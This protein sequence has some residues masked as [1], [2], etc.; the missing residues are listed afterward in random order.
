MVDALCC[1]LGK[2]SY[3]YDHKDIQL[4]LN[5]FTVILLAQL[6]LYL[7]RQALTKD[8]CELSYLLRMSCMCKTRMYVEF[9]TFF[10]L[11]F[12]VAT[13]PP[14]WSECSPD[15]E[16]Y[17]DLECR[18]IWVSDPRLGMYMTLSD[19]SHTLPFWLVFIN[20]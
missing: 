4:I 17:N 8:S 20:L 15:G 12:Q 16:Q 3:K 14:S 18:Y 6:Y 10:C 13:R 7:P 11:F 9:V 5:S 1:L 2:N 19:L